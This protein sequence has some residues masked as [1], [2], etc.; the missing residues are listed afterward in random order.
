MSLLP[1]KALQKLVDKLNLEEFV[2]LSATCRLLNEKMTDNCRLDFP[3]LVLYVS[4]DNGLLS[5]IYNL[6]TKHGIRWLPEHVVREKP[7]TY[8]EFIIIFKVHFS[9]FFGISRENGLTLP[10]FALGPEQQD[11]GQDIDRFQK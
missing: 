11:L 9:P 7:F 3:L 2:A 1:E 4:I 8:Q 10:L 6:H 5:F